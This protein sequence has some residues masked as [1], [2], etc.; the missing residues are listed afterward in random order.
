M[1]YINDSREFHDVESICNGKSSHVPSQPAIVQSLGGMPSR[2]PNLRPGTWNLLGTSGNVFDSPRTVIDSSSTPYQGMLHSFN[3]VLQ[4]KTQCE[5]VQ[6]N[7]SLEVKREIKRRFQPRD[8]QGN[9]Q[10]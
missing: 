4:A 9:H 10:P 5:K 1:N 8:L 6:G 3:K 2:D 7:L